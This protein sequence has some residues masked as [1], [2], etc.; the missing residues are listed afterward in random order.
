[1]TIRRRSRSSPII[2]LSP[3]LRLRSL[4]LKVESV[5][6]ST[7]LRSRG[8]RVSRGIRCTGTIERESIGRCTSGKRNE[9]WSTENGWI[10]DN[11]SHTWRLEEAKFVQLRIDVSSVAKLQQNHQKTH[12]FLITVTQH[13]VTRS[14]HRPAPFLGIDFDG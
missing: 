1:M 12:K 9:R 11:R 14:T 13:F 2:P 8:W 6:R 7:I 3:T 5:L 10:F 4:S